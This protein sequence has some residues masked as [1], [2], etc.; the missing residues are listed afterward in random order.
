MATSSCPSTPPLGPQR[1]TAPRNNSS[2]LDTV[3]GKL[4]VVLAAIERFCISLEL[5]IDTVVTDLTLLYDDHQK[6][7]DKVRCAEQAVANL[8]LQTSDLQSHLATLQEKVGSL[9]E[10][11]E[12]AERRSKGNKIRVV[13][14]PE[15][16]QGSKG[17]T[18]IDTWKLNFVP[19]ELLSPFFSVE[20][21][22][23]SPQDDSILA[24]CLAY[25]WLA[26]CIIVT[27]T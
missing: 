11:K 8:Q 2:D 10:R 23:R 17:E 24:L 9:E 4:D 26:S 16:V 25:W 22:H 6:R 19:V 13:G 14:H 1:T 27:M 20:H 15:G 3:T 7:S 12:N 5:K 21:T 18:Y